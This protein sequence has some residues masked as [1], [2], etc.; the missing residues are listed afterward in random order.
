MIVGQEKP[1]ID[2][3]L[4]HFGV[5]GMKWGT[6]RERTPAQQ[7]KKIN[8]KINK[9]DSEQYLNGLGLI[10]F[11]SQKMHKK[12]LRKN[13]DFNVKKLSKEEETAWAEKAA[14]KSKRASARNGAVAVAVILGGTYGLTR[15][16]RPT[17]TATKGALISGAILAGQVG[18]MSVKEIHSVTIAN[19]VN[20]LKEE[21]KQLGYRPN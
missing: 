9:V 3:A 8:K 12:A 17:P 4:E 2:E 18:L 14:R 5:K 1:S 19:K 6:H 21:R 15:L 13:P 16:G 11:Q 7:I 20:K 10:G